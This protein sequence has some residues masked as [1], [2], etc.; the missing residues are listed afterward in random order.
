[1]DPELIAYLDERFRGIDERFRG[2]DERFRG[3]D[4]RFRETAQQIQELRQDTA[5]QFE[6][7]EKAIQRNEKAI[8]HTGV[9]VEGLHSEIRLVADGV[10]A[11]NQKLE[12]FRGEVAQEF[13]AARGLIRQSYRDLDQRVRDLEVRGKGNP[14]S[15]PA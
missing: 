10:A 9:R 6:R 13:Q 3:I 1:M 11:G 8:R 2:I 14:G 4:E 15:H 7:M 12:S 5:R